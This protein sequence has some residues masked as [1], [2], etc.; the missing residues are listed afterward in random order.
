VKYFHRVILETLEN[1]ADETGVQI[2]KGEDWDQSLLDQVD[3]ATWHGYH[4]ERRL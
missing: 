2:A 1:A 3:I 4:A